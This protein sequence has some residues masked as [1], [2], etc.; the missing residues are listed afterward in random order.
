MDP[1]IHGP[2]D[3]GSMIHGYGFVP[4]I[5]S[6][7]SACAQCLA[8]AMTSQ[9]APCR[10]TPN[11][12][13]DFCVGLHDPDPELGRPT[14]QGARIDPLA[15]GLPATVPGRGIGRNLARI[16]GG[17][18]GGA[19]PPP[20]PPCFSGGL[21]PPGSPKGAPRPR[22]QRLF[23]FSRSS[24]L[25]GAASHSFAAWGRIFAQNSDLF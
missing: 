22:L 10:N 14:D 7:T 21:R 6:R 11:C 2:T 12:A 9:A 18:G 1:D 23:A 13:T 25:S 17:G 20:T 19:A 4:R 3:H 5:G 16:G 8:K 15:I 24:H